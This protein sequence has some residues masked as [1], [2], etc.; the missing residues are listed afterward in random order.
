MAEDEGMTAAAPSSSV[1]DIRFDYIRDR[2]CSCLKVPDSAY[3]KLVSGDGRTSLVQFMEEAH[4]KRLLIMLD[5]KDLSATVKPPPKFKK[6]TVYFLKLQE[7]KLDNDNIK[8]LV[9][10]GEISENP[11]ETLAAIS[12]DVFMPVLT[13]PANQQGW[14]DVVAKEVTE[15]LHKFVSNVFVT[16]GQMKGQTLLPLPPQNTVP[17]LQPEQSMHSL[18]DQDK[19]HILESAIVTWTKQIKN[20]LKADPDAP[21]KEPGAYPGPL[22]ELNFWSERAA[23]L[24]SIHEQLTSEKTQKVVKVLELAKSTYYPAFQR[25]FREVEAAQQEANDNVKFLK[26]LRK[27]LDKL[28]MM[29]DFPMLVDLFKPIMHT[30]MLIWKHSKSYN[31]STRF[32]TLMQEICNDLIMQACKYVPGS[33]LIQME[34]SEAVDKLRMTLR[35]LG[36]FKNYYF[37]YRALSMQDTPENPWKFQ[38]NSLFARLDSFLERCHDMMDLMSTCMQFNRLERVEIGGT[39]GKVLTN[40]VKAIHQD[41]TSAVE[42]FQQVTYDVMDVDAKQFDEDFF[43]FRVVIKELERRLAAIIIQAFDDCTTIGTTFKLLDSFEGLLDRE[44]IAHDLEKKHTD[45]LHSYARDLKDVADLF[46]QYKDRPIV[47][48]NSAP[49]SGAAYWV[50]GLMERIKDPMDRLLTMNKMVLESELFREIQRTYDHLWEEMTEYR[51]RAVDAWC[52]QVAATSDEKLNL[53]LLSLI[54]ETADGIRVLGVNFDPALVRLLRETKYFLLLETSTQD[55]NA[56]RNAEKAAEGGEVE[57]VKKAPKLSVPDSAKDLFAS[58]DTFRQQ[59]SALDLICSIYNKV[60]RTILAVEKPLVQQKL[61]AVEQALNR[62]LAELNWKCAEI[63][64]Y[65]K[66]CMELVKD[67]DLVLNTI[68]DNVKATQG[69][70]AMWEKNLMFERKDGKTYTFDELNDAF[71]QLIQQRHSE[72]RD[73]GKEITKLLSSS[74]RVLKV[75]KGAASWRAYVDYFSNIVIDGFSAAII[76]T[77]RYLLSQIDPDILAKTESSPLLEIQVELVAPDIVW[78]PDLG[79]G[80]AKPGLRDMIKKWLQSFLEIGQ[81]MKRLDVGEGNYAKE[82]EEDF[83]VYDA[84][85]QVMMVTLANESRCEDFKNQFAKFD[86]LWKQDLQATLQQFITDNGVTLPDGTRDDPPLAKFEEQIVKYKNVASE[87]ASFKDTM[88]MGY[89]KVNAKPLRQ[90]LSTWASKWVYLFTHYLQEKVVNSITELYTFMDTSNSTLDLKVMGEGV[91]EEPEYHPDQDPE[92][93]AAKKAAEEEEKRKALYAIMACMRDIRRRTERG[94]DTMFEP[95]K[96]TVTALHTFGIQLSDTVLHQLDNAEFNWRTLKKKMLNRREQL[97]PLQQAEAVEIRRKSDAFNERVEDFRTFFQRKAPFA[98]SGGELKLEQVK[99]AYKLLDEF[100]SGSLEGYPS[101][102]GIIA[103]SKQLQEAQDLFELYQPGYLQLQRCSEELGHLKSLWD[104]VGTVMFTFRDWYK[105]PWD[106][107]DVDFL[108]E[109]TKKLSK[110]I[111]MLNKAV[112]N[113]DVYRMLEEAIKA[114]LTSLPLVQDL[115]HPA[116]RERHWKLLMQTTG[117][118]FVMDD[119]FCLGDLLALELHNYVDAC[120]EIVDRAQKELNIEKQLKKIED[121]WAGLSLAFSTYQ[122]SDVM[123]LLVDDAVNEALEADNLQLQNLSGQKYVQ[124]NPMFL[125][126]VSKWQNNMGRVSAVLETWQNVQKKWQNLESIFIGSADIRVQLPEDSKRFDAVNADFQELM[127]TAPDITNVVEACT[128]DGRQERLENMQSMLEQCEKALQ[129]YLETKR[130]AFPRF[131]FVSP[132]DLL[133]IL[134]KGS[135]PQLILRHLQKCFDNIDN[136]SFRKD[137][138]GDPTKIATHMHS[139]EGEVVEFVEDCSCDGPVEVW[140]QNVVDSMKLALQVEFRKAIPTYDELPRTKWIYVYSAQNT[141]VVS[142][143]FFTQEINEA[144]DD[145]EEGNEEALKVEL[146]RQVQQLADLIDEI[147]KEQTSLDRKKLITLCTID[148]HSRDLVQKLIDERVEDQMCFQWQSQ[149]R[150]IQSEKTKTCQVN[151][152]DAEIAYSYEYIGNCGCLCITPLTDRCFITL[153]QAQRLVLGGAPAGPAGTG[154]TETTKDLAR[155]L[156]IQCYVFNCSDQMDYKAMGHTYK[157]LAQTGAWGCFDEFNRIPVAVLSVCSTQY[158]TVLDAIRAKKERFTFEDADISLKSTV[159]AFITMNPGYPGRAEL[160]ES[161]KALFRPVSMVVPDLALICEI[162][163]MAEGFQMSK[164]LSRKFVILYKLCEDLLSKSRHYDWKLRAIKTTLYVAG[165]MKRAAPELSEDKV[166]LRALRDFN[167]GKLTADD[168]SIFMGLLNDLFPKTLELVPR[169]LDKAFDEAAHKAATELGYQPDDQFLLKISQL[170]ELFVVRWSV[171]L[172]GAAGCGKTAVW[173]TLLRAQNSSGEKTI[174]QAVNP[175]AVTRNELYGYLHPA[176]REWKE[177]LMSVTFRNMANNKTNKHQWIVLD[178]DIDAEWIE[179]M[180]TVM[181]DNKMLTLASNERIPLTP[182]MRLLLEI[183]HMVHCSPATVSRGGVIFIN[184]D[185]VGWQP[186]VASWIDKLEAAEYRPLLTALFTKYVDPCLEHCRRNFKTV[187]P[188]PAVNQA[189]TICKILEGILPKETVRGAP[190][191]DKKLLHYHF[192]FACVWAFGGCMLVDKVTDYRTQFSKWWV[193]EWKDVQFPEK[194]LV[195]DYYV[196]EQN[197]IMVPWE[198]RVT[199]F[200]YIPGDFTSLFVPT[201]ET[202]RLTYFLDSLVSNKHYA[203]F[204]GNTGT[205]KSAIMVNKLRNMDTETMSFYTINMNSLSE[206]PALQV[207]LEQPLEKKSGVRYGPPGSRRM[208]YF[209]D[210]MNMPLVDKYDTQSSIELLRQMVDYHGWYDKVKIQLKEIINCQMAACMNPTAGSFNITP[211]MQ[212]HFVTFAVQMPNAEITRAMYYQII[213][214]HF[215]SFDVDVAKM[216]N[217][218]VDATCELHR[219]V[220]HNFLPSAVKFH[221]QFNLRDLSNITQGLTRAIKEYYREPVKVARLWVHEC[222]RVFRDRMINEADMAKFDEFRVAVTKK[223]FDDCGGMV[224]IEERPLIYA[225]HASMTY[226]PEDVPVYNALSS[227]DVLRKTLEDKLREYN[228]SNAVM[229]LVLF[230][231]AMEHVTRIARIIDLPRGN[232]MLVGVGGSGKQSLARLASYICGY[233]VYQISVSSTYGINDFKENL[234]G[235]YRKAG[236]KGT[237]ITFLM[238][239][240]QIVKEGFLVYIN[241]LL[242]TGYIADLFTPEDKEAFTNAVRNE[243]KA[244]GILDSAENCWDFFIDKVRKFLHIVLCFSPVGDKFRIRA[245]QFPALVN[246]T[247]FDWFHGWPGEALVSVAQR[248]LVDVPNMEEV[249]RENIAYHMAYAHQCVSEASE[250][251]KEAFRRYNYTTPKSYLELISL[252]KM[253]LQLK[254][255]DLRRSKER[256]ENGIDKIAQAAAQV[257]DLQRVL[258]EEQIVVDEKKAQTDELIVSIGKEKAIVDQAVEAGR[259]DEEAATALQTEVSAFQAECE[260]DLLEAEPIIAQAEAALNSLN[261]KELSELKSFGSPAAEIVQVAAACLVLTCGG[262]IPKDRDWNA[263]KKMMADVNSFLSSLMNFDKDNVPVV[264]VEVVEKDYISNPGFTPDNIKGK[265]AACAGLCS[266]VINIC[267]Y[268]RIYQVVAPKRAALAEANKKL[269]TANKKLKVIRDEVKRLQ[270]RVALLE[271]SLMKATEDKNAAIAQADRTARKAQMAERLINGL[272]GENTRWGAEIKRLESLEGR[273][274]GDVLIASAFVSYAG[275]FNMQFR[276]SLVDEKWLPDIIER[277]IPMTQGIRPLDLLTDDATKAKWANE[278]LPTDP[279]SVENGAIMSNASRWALMI[280]PQLQGI[281]WIINKETNNGLVIIQQ[282]QPK[283]IDQVIN[284]IENG[285]PLLI[286]NLP[287]DIDAVLDPVIGK[288][289]IKKGRNIIMKIGDAEV[290]YDSRFRLYLQ[291]KLSNPHF[292]PEVAA[293]TTLVN[294]CVTEKGLEDQLLALVVDHERP[295]LQ[296][297][298]A[299]LVRSLNE[300]NI[301]LVELENNLLFNLA[302]ATGNILENIE[303]IEGLEETKRTA[304]EIE[305]KVKLAKQT[306]IQI[307]KAREVYRPVATRGSLTYFLIDNLNALDRVYHYSMANFVFVLKKGMDMTPG[308]KD[309]SKVPLAERLNQEV[310]LDKRV[311]LLVETTCF[312]LIGYVAQGLFERHKLIVA[313]QLCMQILRS[314]GELHYA[315]FEYLLRGPKVMGADNPLHDWVSDSVWGSVQ[316]LKELDDYQGLPED[317]IGSSKRWREW[318]ELERPE[319]EPLPGD[320]KRMQEFDK[321]LLFRALRPDRLTSAMGRFVT[322]M[323]GAKYVTSQPYDLERSYQDASP[324]TPIFVFLSPGVDVAGSVEALGKKLGFTLDNGKYASVSLGQGQEPIAMDRLS[325]AHKNGGWVLLQN[326]HLTIDWTTNQLDKKV[327]KLVEGAHPDFRLFLSAE[328]PPSLERGLPISLLQN[329]IKLTNEP[330]EGLKANLRRAWNN[331]NEEILESCAKQAEFRAIVFALCYFH[332]ALLERKKFGVGNLPGARSGIG[333]NMNYPFNT[334]DLLCCGQTANNYLE[335]NVKV[336]WEDLRYNFGE[337]MYGG[338]IVED[339]DRRLAMC[340]LRKYVN[341]GLLDNMEFFPGF[342]MPPNTANH[343]QVLEFI[344]EVMPPE[345]PLAFGL[346]PN[347]E[348]GFKLREA[349]SF[350][351]SLVQLQPRESS[352]EGGMSAEERAKLVLDEVVDKLPDIFDMEDVRSKINP[353][354]PN[355]PFVM[356]AIQESERMNMLLAEMKR[357]LLELD[358]GLKGDLTMTEPMERLLKALA[359]DA[360]PGSWRNLAYPSLRPLGSWLGNLLARHAQLVDWTAE[361]STPKAVWLSGL[362]NPQ[363]FL[364]AVMQATARR[365][366]WPLDKTVIIT[367]VTKKQPDQIEANSRDGA[368]IHGLTLEGARW[369]DKIGAL[370]D[371]KPKELFCPMPVILVRAVTQ[372][373]A[374]MKDVYKCPVYTTEARFREE[375]FEAQLKSKHTEIKWVLAG[376]CLFLD[377]V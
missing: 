118:H 279:L 142:R 249:V 35:V 213:D 20:V 154:K 285:W 200:Q 356:V 305:E 50:R 89:V 28:N 120:S 43:G 296:E 59:I 77:V 160:P 146:D 122:D 116:M 162:M 54:E 359:T 217:K 229:D 25:L 145:L 215:S 128:L 377:V 328:P 334:G 78:K 219:N 137:E 96:E 83:E 190:P 90:A 362:F 353:D 224:A 164:I 93:A 84:L 179:S 69:I 207:I 373:K 358:L 227:Y 245:R 55:K 48:K 204:V 45:L 323:L 5:G 87:I 144:F 363:S 337:I 360:V 304:V 370:D 80:G 352:G 257:T 82:L 195:Y 364:T 271:Q 197:C 171:F 114:V 100:R 155:A 316:A 348:I 212:R 273:L 282:S 38:N 241:D 270:D 101:V 3:D 177:G 1:K 167:L 176:T 338:H 22:T 345:T 346:H 49:Y 158:K 242:S 65:I 319:D 300:Y 302:N 340:Y 366:D 198:D 151:I 210:D 331:F 306:E 180:N 274:V 121:T 297:Q 4:T 246:C 53:P 237:P 156:G 106:K 269:D 110:D 208:V 36:T 104:T 165:G 341:E 194:G 266:W 6:K 32:V 355:M 262:K 189:M 58:A 30:L 13:A 27:Y 289:T 351:N 175:K 115:H 365:N 335:N 247:M 238:T 333:W 107:I 209:V 72:I 311:E 357:S 350:C 206:A 211:R 105:T 228:E 131:Y 303:L 102:L 343:R 268:F 63:D 14:P 51:T 64:T 307:A 149:L 24:N 292:K 135:N 44:V 133:D 74:N 113:Y 286:E 191:P 375:V 376:V 134:S 126:T 39:K 23:N 272:S 250:R 278:G 67:V 267:K 309:E 276:K 124:S 214:G 322:N 253:L 111:K 86:Y 239:D 301:T 174:Y 372:D 184:A 88:T 47:A 152:C 127:R 166:L 130:V 71:N 312:V 233:E 75:S 230:Q 236:T 15:N 129:E 95:L 33:D 354:D 196:D 321:L 40:G 226:T 11:L 62:G 46:H 57:V 170:R 31:S 234:L 103:E 125:E 26:P 310:D 99:P 243:V 112:R 92:E 17:T 139:K 314:R 143:T 326:I 294:F 68:K 325:A 254:R 85:N 251:F 232:A 76:S 275:P 265:S 157:G 223:F 342:A 148:V 329:S 181:D 318:M 231:Q 140:L 320:W 368:F 169:A 221:Y 19:I 298:A 123:A 79:E 281:K 260:R 324:G 264:C 141:V 117:K 299:G 277:Q 52:A 287:V 153:T 235:L 332:A 203:M 205:G 371:S 263:G 163:L 222:E 186:V 66:E 173:R 94:T 16:I 315:K 308:G 161:L 317:L 344:D 183:N 244:A 138:R 248:F 187:V 361:L 182:S 280:D 293:Q 98:V 147:N 259:E 218:L 347:A 258:K 327:D 225:S 288:M 336:P 283:Y 12:Q 313:T 201:V 199:K 178:G 70:L 220:M 255:D 61:D 188:L 202:T 2:V 192:V 291:T 290:Q 60:Q 42:K 193:S 256:L 132:A 369:D 261:K 37:E 349:E 34:P 374:E 109:E 10:H 18:K 240:N 91:E 330:P 73:A 7:T 367:E 9:I 97:A 252:Y 56:D 150:Y 295:D 29:D 159:M 108:V 41:F 284:C 168:T 172:L 185:D 136:L 21:L 216:S 119:K 339:Y 81:L 8:K